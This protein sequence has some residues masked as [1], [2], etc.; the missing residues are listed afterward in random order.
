M[1]LTGTW[2]AAIADEDLRRSWQEASF[3][4]TA[5]EPIEVPSHWRS[6]P[7]FAD[8]D[9]SL[10]YRHQFATSDPGP[11]QRSWLTFDGMFYQGDVWLD[12]AYLGD[13]EGYFAPHTFE[14][15]D[16][17]AARG[18]HTLA[19]EVNCAPQTDKTAKR[20]ITGVFQHWDC[21]GQDWNPGGI[22]RPVRLTQT[23]PVRIS[24]LRVLCR[25]A[26]AERAVVVL[27]A[28][29]GSDAART[30]KVSTSVGDADHTAE[31]PLAAGDN[32]VEWTITVDQPRL[33]WP[34][35]LGDPVLHDVAVRVSLDDDA[36]GGLSDE[37][38]MRTGLRQVRMRSWI[39]SVNGERLFLKGANQGPTRM[40]LAEASPAEIAGDV[41]LAVDAGLDLLRIHAHI[42]RNELYDAADEA[43]LLLWQDFPLQWGYARGIRKQAVR[44]AT[45]A[46]DL[47]GH[48]PSI[49]IWC[50]HNEPMAI[51]NDPTMWGEPRAVAR[52]GLRALA[53][54]ELPTWNKTVL[55]R[56]VKRAFEKGDGTRPVIA[57]SGVL[58]HPPQLDGTDSHL[59]FGWYHGH[60]RDLP[61]F[62]RA[63]PRMGRFVS[64]FGAQAV[65]T[66]AEFCDP[67]RWPDLDWERLGRDHALQKAIFDRLVPPADYDTFEAWQAATQE[68]QA[69]LLRRQIEALRRIK[70]RPTGGL[71]L[72]CL[73]DGHPAITWS[74]VGHD[75][76]PKLGYEAVRAACAPVIIVADR[77]PVQVPARSDLDLDVHVVSDLRL[78]LD[79]AEVTAV[80]R[81][82]GGSRTW[83]WTGDIPTDA[84]ERVGTMHL[85]VSDA[86]GP[87]SL[88]LRCD[89]PSLDRAVTNRDSTTVIAR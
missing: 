21:F 82:S 86:L 47:L 62:L 76:A 48:H 2:R 32:E 42:S 39:A 71:A 28:T 33:W 59:Y 40:A 56:S 84:C 4:D 41:A 15:T 1:E 53:A 29:L 61:G 80:L 27:R 37:R 81:W 65:P 10:L 26:N 24:R 3:D 68:Y 9:G 18:E 85:A 70:Y 52:M 5:W 89:H 66:T 87:L 30:V 45:Q 88:E 69:Q 43:G 7:A 57:H 8:T 19:V 16:A 67:E 11:G 50:G 83:R 20:N 22:W 23:G 34:R 63:M 31:Q 79:G 77:L 72:F 17:L 74:I 46:V 51:E 75:R 60:E 78:P 38:R 64:E 25:D 36:G 44:Q 13:T 58:P 14:V 55:D 6:T 35:A 12:G 54:Q 49:A 73:A